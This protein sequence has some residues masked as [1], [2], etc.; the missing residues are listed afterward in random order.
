MNRDV[1]FLGLGNMGTPMALN[2]LRNGVKLH[3][4]NRTKEKTAPLVEEG[5]ELLT[6]ADQ[7]FEKSPIAFFWNMAAQ[8]I[9]LLAWR[10]KF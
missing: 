2:L 8:V 1:S 4:Y 6:A 5:A 3:V 10:M 9:M 7:A